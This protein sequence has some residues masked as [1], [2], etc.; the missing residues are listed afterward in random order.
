MILGLYESPLNF[1]GFFLNPSLLN[2]L[3]CHFAAP[4]VTNIEVSHWLTEMTGAQY[5]Y[6]MRKFISNI[7]ITNY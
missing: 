6:S 3:T 5:H 2:E 1:S 7:L 4:Q